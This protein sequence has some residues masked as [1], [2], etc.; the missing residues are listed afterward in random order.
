MNL[1]M[2]IID[3]INR[4]ISALKESYIVDI[5]DEDDDSNTHAEETFKNAQTDRYTICIKFDSRFGSQQ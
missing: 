1:I 5:D 3:R 4:N 2:K